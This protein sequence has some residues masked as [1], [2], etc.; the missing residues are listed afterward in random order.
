M[1]PAKVAEWHR[2]Q[3]TRAQ[4]LNPFHS[5]P[6]RSHLGPIHPDWSIQRGLLS[7][8]RDL[9]PVERGVLSCQRGLLL[10]KR[11]LLSVARNLLSPERA[12]LSPESGLLS[13]EREHWRCESWLLSR[14]SA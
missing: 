13:P 3:C 14:E 12:L 7:Q 5:N 1:R 4:T 6:L 9:L 10:A 8:E 2:P 11:G